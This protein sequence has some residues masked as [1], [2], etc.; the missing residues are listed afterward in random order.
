MAKDT[1]MQH[2]Q[3]QPAAEPDDSLVARLYQQHALS[4]MMYVRRHVPAREEAEDILLDVFL[5]AVEHQELAEY[6]EQRQLAWLQ[7]VAY[8]KCVDYH[9]RAA[10]RSAVPLEEA[11]TMLA[12]DERQSPDQL[13]VR[14]EEDKLLYERLSRLPES[15]QQV[16][17][18]RFAQGLSSAE[19]AH[20]LH[21]SDG[22]IR[23]ILSRALTILRDACAGMKEE[24]Q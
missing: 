3:R 15:Y 21:K 18:L 19:I 2:G 24:Q 1:C 5:A 7:R 13:A 14:S 20:R 17:Q 12:D 10:R 22:A 23:M 11:S 8:H 16:L 9:R 6:S 4:I